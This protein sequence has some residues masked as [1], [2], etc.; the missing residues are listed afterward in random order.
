MTGSSLDARAAALDAADPLASHRSL[1]IGT[2]EG[3]DGAED[4]GPDDVRAAVT[5][6]AEGC[7]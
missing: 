5:A 7:R 4:V 1:V 6:Y 2:D 3:A